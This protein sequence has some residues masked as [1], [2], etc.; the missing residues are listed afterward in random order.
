METRETKIV[1]ATMYLNYKMEEIGTRQ[2]LFRL[3]MQRGP[4]CEW[5]SAR[6]PSELDLLYQVL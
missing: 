3:L 1:V 5:T 2:G 4:R 6:F